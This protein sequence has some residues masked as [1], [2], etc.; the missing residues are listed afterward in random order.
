MDGEANQLLLTM[1][2]DRLRGG[3]FPFWDRKTGLTY[4]DRNATRAF[5][6]ISAKTVARAKQLA[7]DVERSYSIHV[8]RNPAE[9]V[10][11][12][13]DE[14]IKPGTWV[15]THVAEIYLMLARA[16]LLRTIEAYDTNDRLCGAILGIQLGRAYVAETMY[17]IA[18]HRDA[19]KACLVALVH[20]QHNLG[21][22]FID[23]Q[24][25]HDAKHPSRVLGEEVVALDD[26]LAM[27][28][29][30]IR[31][32]TGADDAR[33]GAIDASTERAWLEAAPNVRL[34]DTSSLEILGHQVM[35]EWELPLMRAMANAASCANGKVLEVGYGLG[36]CA[37]LI[38]ENRPS[39]HVVIE[40]NKAVSA[41]AKRVFA[42]EI[43]AGTVFVV[44]D[45]WENLMSAKSAGPLADGIFDGVVFDTFPLTQQDLRKNH[46][47]F[48]AHA[49]RLL[50]PG[51]RFTYFSDEP[52]ALSAE[53]V[54]AI[55]HHFPGATFSTELLS[56]NPPP[57]CD[58]WKW[59]TIV[60]VVVRKPK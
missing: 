15:N 21:T 10:R 4:W 34:D 26:Y 39:L 3:W 12:L 43:A 9:V 35:Q 38:Q 20:Q 41:R 40:A 46:F 55:G 6:P 44:E 25:A 1:V 33:S 11:Q 32:P 37:G 42:A 58:Y 17:S 2:V 45:Y 28:D 8:S 47:A 52:V 23:V 56:V 59:P 53:H 13:Q 22:R 5:I 30:A 49:A 7:H 16:G 54:S 36:I 51:G 31:A 24:V 27:L 19:S 48:F 14:G 18:T 50:R 29:E 60:H 57:D